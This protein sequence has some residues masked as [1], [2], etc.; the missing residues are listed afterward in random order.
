MN[1]GNYGWPTFMPT[2]E[3]SLYG[4]VIDTGIYYTE[5]TDCFAL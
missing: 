4:G 3:V 5:S 2:D 1:C